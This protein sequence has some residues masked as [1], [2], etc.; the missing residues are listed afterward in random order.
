VGEGLL[1]GVVSF[2]APDDDFAEFPSDVDFDDLP[3]AMNEML[4]KD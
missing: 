4:F 2:P 1:L 3:F